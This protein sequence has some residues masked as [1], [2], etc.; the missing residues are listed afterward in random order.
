M[1]TNTAITAALDFPTP[2]PPDQDCPPNSMNDIIQKVVD[3][4]T[5]VASDVEN[6]QGQTDSTA[7]LALNAANNALQ[8]VSALAGQIPARRSSGSNLIPLGAGGSLIPITWSPVMPNVNYEVNVTFFCPD[9]A[10]PA[11]PTIVGVVTDSRTV[12]GCVLRFMYVPDNTWEFAYSVT[13]L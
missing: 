4:V 8:Q 10:A 12:S 3:N 1:P 9:D 7:E 2:L 6:P 13:A 11:P 5:I